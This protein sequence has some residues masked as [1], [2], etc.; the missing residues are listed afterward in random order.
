MQQANAREIKR[1]APS[2][3]APYKEGDIVSGWDR[4]GTS[5]AK[6]DK[7]LFTPSY[8]H[9][10]DLRVLW[11]HGRANHPTMQALACCWM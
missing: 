8:P 3:S 4:D 10:Y 11:H 1:D 9:Y 2:S 6:V 7:I 5:P